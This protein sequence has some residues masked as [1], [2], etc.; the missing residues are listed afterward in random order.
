M[1]RLLIAFAAACVPAILAGQ[2]PGRNVNMVTGITWPGGD[3]F[4]QRQNEPSVAASSRNP[5]HLLAGAN[6]YRTIDLPGLPDSKEVGDAWMGLFKSTNGGA[7]WTSTL[8][9]GY[10]QDS[11]PEGALSP[12]KE[13]TAAADPVVRAGTNGLFYYSGIVFDR[14]TPTKSG[15]FVARFIDNNNKEAGDPIVYLGTTLVASNPGTEFIDKPWFAVDI[16]R[17]GAQTCTITTTQPNATPGNPNGTVTHNQSF[18]GGAAYIVYSLISGEGESTRSQVYFSR[19]ENCGLNWSAPLRISSLDDPINQGATLAIDPRNGSIFIAWRRFS[20]DGTDDTIMVTRSIDQGRKWD[21]PGRARRFPRG[22]KVG[23]Q[24]EIHG[25]KFKQPVELADLSSL[26]QPT[27]PDRFRTNAYPTMTVDDQ[28]RIYVAWAERGFSPWNPD[29]DEGDARVLIATSTNVQTWTDP[30]PV[31]SLLI[32]GHQAMPAIAFAGGKI[33][34]AYYDFRDD[35]SQVWR[36]W[37]DET[38]AIQLGMKRHTVDVRAAMAT[39]GANPVFGPSVQVSEYL[40]GSRPGTGPRPVEQLQFNPPNLKLFQ[41]GTVPFFGD[42][43]DLSPSPAFVPVPGGWAYNTAPSSSPLFHVVWT[44]NRDVIP[45]PDGNWTNYTPPGVLP[46]QKSLTDPTITLNPCVPGRAGMRNQNLYTAR[47]TGGLVAGSPGNSKPLDPLLQRGFVVFAQN[48]TDLA[49][50]FELTIENQPVGGRASFSQYPLPPFDATSPPPLTVLQVTVPRR[51]TIARTV[52]ATSTDPHAQIHVSVVEI[53]GVGGTEVPSGLESTVVLNPDISN[54][55]ISNPDISNPDISNPDIS[56]PD[57]SNAEVH[58]PDISNPD[59]SNP[60]ISN[61]DI[62]NPDISNPDISNPDISNTQVANPDISNPDI[63]NPDISNPDISNPDISNPDISNPDISNQ[64]LTD[65]TWTITNDGNTTTA[66]SIKLLLADPNLA[67]D[68]SLIVVQLILRKVYT[69]PVAVDCELALHAHNVL[70]ANIV[71]PVFTTAD[72]ISNPDISNPDISNA[73][74]WLAPGESAKITIRTLDLN[75]HDT[76][77]F[78]P[79]EDVVPV[80]VSQAVNTED[81]ATPGA[82]PPLAFPSSPFLTFIQQ[83]TAG[84]TNAPLG[85]VRVTVIDS[86]GAPLPGVGPV[87]LRVYHMPDAAT[88][89][90]TLASVTN[91]TGIATF[92]IGTFGVGGTYLMKASILIGE[93]EEFTWSDSF[94]LTEPPGV[95]FVVTNTN[96][97]GPGSLAQAI[98]DANNN[99]PSRD[100][101]AFNIDGAGPHV[102]SPTSALPSILQPLVIDGT[103]QPGYAGV[104]N[105]RLDGGSAGTVDGLTIAAPVTEVRGLG[106]TGYFAVAVRTTLAGDAALIRGNYIGVTGGGSAA[107]NGSGIELNTLDNVV[108]GS[109]AADRNVISGNTG[110]GVSIQGGIDI[111]GNRIIGNYIGTTPAGTAALANGAGGVQLAAPSTIGG[112]SPS[113]GNLISG[114]GG[115]GISLGGDDHES[116]IQGNL[117]GTNAAGGAA[118]PN[119]GHGIVI[120]DTEFNLIGGTTPGARNLISGNTGAGI[121]LQGDA[122]ATTIHG[123]YIGVNA[124]G[125]AAIGNG[126]GGVVIDN[127]F[128]TQLGGSTA[129]ERNVISGNAQHGVLLVDG[130]GNHI[131]GNYIGVNAAGAADIGVDLGNLQNGVMLTGESRQNNIGAVGAG[132]VISGNNAN[133]IRID[134]QSDDNTIVANRIGTNAAGTSAIG[135]GS[136]NETLDLVGAGILVD[137]QNTQIGGIGAGNQISGNGVG[138]SLTATAVS[139]T[140]QG[141]LIGTSADGTA[142]LGNRWG[143]FNAGAASTLIGGTT[144]GEGNVISGSTID[145]IA[146][147]I[148]SSTGVRIEGNRIGTSSDGMTA[149]GNTQAGISVRFGTTGVT[150]GGGDASAGN[151][152]SGNNGV[153]I[154]LETS[155]NVVSNNKIG[156]DASFTGPLGNGGGGLS[157][158]ANNTTVDA[159]IIAFNTNAGISATGSGNAFLGNTIFDNGGLGIDQGGDGVTANDVPDADGVQ[160]YPVLESVSSNA[161][162]TEILGSLQTTPGANVEIRFYV[163]QSCDGSGNGE[164]QLQFASGIFVAD[165]DTGVVIIDTTY[166]ISVTVGQFVTAIARNTATNDTSEFSACVTVAGAAP[167]PDATDGGDGALFLARLTPAGD[168]VSGRPPWWTNVQET[169]SDPGLLLQPPPGIRDE[170]LLV[171]L[172]LE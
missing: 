116:I 139:N 105:V 63:S 59:I 149:I 125:T 120:G 5:L 129:A 117:I 98:L 47:I 2:I 79:A 157:I 151:L 3:P 7:T 68:P 78:E 164:G 37:I 12:L 85:F 137:G 104:P 141:N 107:P 106:I 90:R 71:D 80:A 73:T 35:V 48:A 77:T 102:I 8:L 91:E 172:R 136:L 76:F 69:T 60:D 51:S 29:L 110:W 168:S 169:R 146:V 124:A 82:Q 66:Y 17:V 41:L 70:L 33:M 140:I 118:V 34:L 58:N 88:P 20:A 89:V 158:A 86:T 55:D 19:S 18:P 43:I 95:T 72:Q 162:G 52:Y 67:P 159:N 155:G 31:D 13:Y 49:K 123:N 75:I 130:V 38:S 167:E 109:A 127:T 54:P 171:P 42:Y 96:A 122:S 93:D 24:K 4:L 144:P 22:K 44:D 121:R 170:P 112:A 160:N 126:G 108:G 64:S 81:E 114:N 138:V 84:T 11:S 111:S 161:G 39:P 16:P 1:Q 135:N 153:G 45:P 53:T 83:P 119:N 61:P 99:G 133:G 23:L 154:R 134:V 143:I 145:G 142:D 36:Q 32:P 10:P 103:T 25:R 165:A 87:T 163:N 15:L 152:I 150:I 147:T 101:I 131:E 26:D 62:S 148:E 132:N 57:I 128:S 28:G 6:D 50:T 30:Q 9:P 113:L 56:N 166:L 27:Q 46:G 74:L 115:P 14:T 40:F 21:P 94:V 65:T 97:T 156:V 92:D 100:T